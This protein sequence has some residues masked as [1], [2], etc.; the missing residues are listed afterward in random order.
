MKIVLLNS[1]DRKGGA[2]RAAFHLHQGLNHHGVDSRMVVQYKSS[3]DPKVHGPSGQAA[4][5]VAKIRLRLDRLPL[6]AY[7]AWQPSDWSVQWFWNNVVERVHDLKP[8]LVHIHWTGEGFLPISSLSKFNCPLVW[9]MY[10]MWALTGGCHYDQECGRWQTNCG[11]C[12]QLGSHKEN[13]LS[14]RSWEAKQSAWKNLPVTIVT[15]SHWLSRCFQKSPIFKNKTFKV[16]PHGMDKN[17]F[18]H[19]SKKEARRFLKLPEEGC[20]IVFGAASKDR[21]KGFEYLPSA[22]RILS[23]R[24]WGSKA[25][26][27]IFGG[28]AREKGLMEGI[29]TYFLGRINGDKALSSVYAAAD[30]MVVPSTQDNMPLTII[31]AMACGT[32]CV[33]FNIGGMPDLID[34]KINGYLADPFQSDDLAKGIEWVLEDDQRRLSLCEHA[35]KKMSENFTS[36]IEVHKYVQLYE[37]ILGQKV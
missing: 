17:V 18:C 27:G 32:P 11:L 24:G 22:L 1:Y 30:V 35:Y 36:E 2:A 28:T 5:I 37:E 8:D 19:I 9:S 20:L 10:D 16:I 13:D 25:K 7:P 21:R 12:P 31:E 15:A 34:H 3:D 6:L 4:E 14:R 26:I 29:E 33:A 23:E